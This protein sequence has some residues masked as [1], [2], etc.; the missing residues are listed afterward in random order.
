MVAQ[1][2]RGNPPVYTKLAINDEAAF[3]LS[4]FGAAL[5][6]VVRAKTGKGQHIEN[7]LID[8]AVAMQSGDFIQYKGMER[9]DLG[10]SDIKGSDATRRLYQCADGEWFFLFIGDEADWHNLCKTLGVENLL[11]DPRFST[12][13]NRRDKDAALVQILS[14][15]FRLTSAAGWVL[16]LQKVGIAAV[17]AKN[18]DDVLKDPHCLQ[19]NLFV[20]QDDPVFGPSQVVGVMPKFS[21]MQGIV[22]RPTPAVGE[23]TDGILTELGYT[24]EQILELRAKK[25]VSSSPSVPFVVDGVAYGRG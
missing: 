4:A 9:K 1:G 11:S 7:C 24:E 16:A 10:G 25:A 18:I 21:E 22:R 6:L 20:F 23:H 15:T 5:A 3:M 14:E 13:E 19:N 12:P 17:L 2:G 8:A